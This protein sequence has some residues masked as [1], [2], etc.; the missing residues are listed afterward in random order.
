MT[1]QQY[2]IILHCMILALGGLVLLVVLLFAQLKSQL[3]QAHEYASLS[4][5]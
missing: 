4:E 3:H 2:N 1:K 5:F